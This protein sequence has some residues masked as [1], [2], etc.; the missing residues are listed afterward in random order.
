MSWKPSP[1]AGVDH[2]TLPLDP[3]RGYLLSR[4]DGTLDVP[5]LASLMN[6]EE[7]QVTTLLGELVDLGAVEAAVPADPQV[8]PA[9]PPPRPEPGPLSEPQAEAAEDE[10]ESPETRVRAATHRQLFEE[11]LHALPVDERVALARVAVEPELSACC[12]DPTPE[13]IRAVLDNP[14]AGTLHGRLIASHHRTAA[15]LEALGGRLAFTNDSGVRRALL[16]NPLLPVALFRRLWSPRRLLEQYLVAA[17]HDSPEQVRAMA[18]DLLRSTFNQRPG[19]ERAELILTTEGRCLAGMAGLTL[20][21]HATALLCRRTYISTLFIQNL[22]R[23]SAA[24]P[25]LIAHLRRQDAVKRNPALRQL[26]E[27]HP[28][29]T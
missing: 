4:L 9:P 27:R 22:A 12:F 7:A 23:W 2:L 15:G 24:P 14:H 18:R 10:A 11:R 1:R 3:L 17:S 16:Q 28:N 26:L 25:P 21:S 29:A 20:D 5:T 6:L 19:E 8:P 13:V